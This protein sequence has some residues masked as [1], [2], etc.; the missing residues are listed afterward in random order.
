MQIFRYLEVRFI[1]IRIK[2]CN[3]SATYK[4]VEKL[5]VGLLV[6]IVVIRQTGF[7]TMFS[8]T[9]FESKPQALQQLAYVIFY[10]EQKCT[11]KC[12]PDLYP[13]YTSPERHSVTQNTAFANEY[14]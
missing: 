8:T 10:L 13:I 5:T 4:Q 14:K 9:F 1:H 2:L 7:K 12:F 3:V 11:R 6:R